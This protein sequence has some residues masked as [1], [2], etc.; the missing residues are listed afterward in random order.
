[1]IA[2]PEAAI[3]TRAE[4]TIR[5]LQLEPEDRTWSRELPVT[6]PLR[7]CF[8]LVA[9]LPLVEAVVAVDTALHAGLVD[10]D[11]LR[12]YIADHSAVAGVVRARRA[13][14]HAEPKS[15]SPMETRLR[16]LLVLR[17]LPRPEAQVSVCDPSGGFLGRPDLYYSE[18]GLGLEYDGEN[19]RDRL[20]ADNQRQNRLQQAGIRLLR[21][22]APDLAQRPD[23]V[24]AE[25]RAALSGRGPS[26]LRAPLLRP[27]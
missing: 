16:M 4:A 25:V 15:E 27:G 21:Y 18:A 19:H 7:T 26:V 5:R 1:M 9:R 14:E 8:D 22:T 11:S 10:L 12:A 13:I 2:L 6:S 17:G 23:A 24:V 3:S 20:T